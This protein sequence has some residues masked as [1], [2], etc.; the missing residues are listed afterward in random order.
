MLYKNID[1]YVWLA[2]KYLICNAEIKNRAFR[3]SKLL[4]FVMEE[5]S[6]MSLMIKVKCKY[7]INFGRYFFYLFVVCIYL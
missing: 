5:S 6:V 1:C 4:T 3:G 2:V 7:I